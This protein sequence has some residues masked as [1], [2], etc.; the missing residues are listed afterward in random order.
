MTNMQVISVSCLY[1]FCISISF[2]RFQEIP[3][4]SRSHW[5]ILRHWLQHGLFHTSP[6]GG[7]SDDMSWVEWHGNDM[8]WHVMAVHHSVHNTQLMI[9][10][11]LMP[12]YLSQ[13]MCLLGTS[14]DSH[15]NIGRET[16]QSRQYEWTASPGPE[17]RDH[18]IDHLWP[19]NWE[20]KI[21]LLYRSSM[22]ITDW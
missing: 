14:P 10:W 9:S 15:D 11:Y 1:H 22:T 8:E 16:P 17:P 19:M 12:I 5:G 20:S 3:D 2:K 13:A 4:Y 21:G 7:G 18:R 6:G